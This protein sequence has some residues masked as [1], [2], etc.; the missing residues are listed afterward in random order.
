VHAAPRPQ[1]RPLLQ[2]C[3]KGKHDTLAAIVE[4]GAAAQNVHGEPAGAHRFF[5]E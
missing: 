1:F 5:P 4:G 2:L 3:P